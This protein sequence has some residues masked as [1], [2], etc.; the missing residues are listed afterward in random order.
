[1]TTAEHM[2][3]LVPA[4]VVPRLSFPDTAGAQAPAPIRGGDLFLPAVP[5]ALAEQVI[6][7]NPGVYPVSRRP[8]VR[9]YRSRD[10][11]IAAVVSSVLAVQAA[12]IPAV[13]GVENP[14]WHWLFAPAL[15]TAALAAAYMSIPFPHVRFAPRR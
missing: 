2:N 15:L 4:E 9:R 7:Q 8:A 3:L 14:Y 5:A 11:T 13:D 1:M 6:D 10:Y 12:I